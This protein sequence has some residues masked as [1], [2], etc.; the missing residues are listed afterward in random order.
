[1]GENCYSKEMVCEM[2]SR[3][4]HLEKRA[5][6]CN[7]NSLHVSLKKKKK[8]DYLIVLSETFIVKKKQMIKKKDENNFFFLH[9]L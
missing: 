8:I 3:S 1:M 2:S 9:C 5:S 7:E 6:A 4:L